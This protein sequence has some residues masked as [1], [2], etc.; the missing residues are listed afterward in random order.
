VTGR[1]T[2][3]CSRCCRRGQVPPRLKRHAL[4]RR[5]TRDGLG[6][7]VGARPVL[8]VGNSRLTDRVAA[9]ARGPIAKPWRICGRKAAGYVRMSCAVSILRMQNCFHGFI[10]L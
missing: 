9:Y 10:I 6:A 7:S 8:V 4:A 1:L 5:C 3:A 2:S